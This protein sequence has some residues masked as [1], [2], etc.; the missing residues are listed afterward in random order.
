V[1]AAAQLACLLEVSVEKPGNV[2]PTHLLD[3]AVM[4]RL[5]A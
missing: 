5:F 3:D 4:R 1:A 2:T